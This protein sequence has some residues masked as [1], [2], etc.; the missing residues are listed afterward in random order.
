M[1]SQ[2][3]HL[4]LAL[5]KSFFLSFLFFGE[6]CCF[7]VFEAFG[8]YTSKLLLNHYDHL[9]VNSQ[10]NFLGAADVIC[11]HCVC[12]RISVSRRRPWKSVFKIPRHR[13]VLLCRFD[14]VILRH[15]LWILQTFYRAT[16]KHMHGIAIST[17]CMSICLSVKCMYCDKT[18]APSKKSS[19]MTNRKLPTSFPMSRR[20]T[21][22]VASKP[23]IRLLWKFWF[24]RWRHFTYL[25]SNAHHN[26]VPD[27]TP[28]FRLS[29]YHTRDPHLN[30][31][32]SK[33]LLPVRCALT[34]HGS[35]PTCWLCLLDVV[36]LC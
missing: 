21:A 10:L 11:F 25:W 23:P 36:T 17:F 4:L 20:W 28:A 13:Q 26:Y 1:T 14:V 12:Q 29:H 24:A 32:I 30:G 6:A 35:G 22:Y 31:L 15:N 18:K 19:S 5:Q 8:G 2:G 34:V 33:C 16:A 3:I 27:F 7:S 9:I